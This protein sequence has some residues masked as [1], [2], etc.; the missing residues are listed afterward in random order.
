[1]I[2]PKFGDSIYRKFIFTLIILIVTVGGFSFGLLAHPPSDMELNYDGKTGIL[3]VVVDHRVGNPSNHYVERITIT[4]NGTLV[5]EE[6]YERQDDRARTSHEYRINAQNGDSVEVEAECNRFGTIS[7]SI[8]VEGV[9]APGKIILQANL[10]TETEIPE[11][12]E[13]TPEA[14][15]GL[16]IA[17]LDT[18]NMTIQYSITYTGLSGTPTMAHFHSGSGE[19]TGPPVRTIFGKPEVEG[20]PLAPPEGNSGFITGNWPGS[21]DQTLTAEIIDAILAGEI[22]I[23]IHTELNKG[24]EIRGQLTEVD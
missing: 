8:S 23:N 24:G 16:A 14:A 7:R 9:E 3:T 10:T 19:E 1:M 5:L 18:K 6:S 21:G 17:L 13:S 2:K 11:V 12:A 4:K 20:A 22:Y 15:S